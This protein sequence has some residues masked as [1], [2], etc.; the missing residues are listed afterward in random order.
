LIDRDDNEKG[1]GDGPI[2]TQHSNLCNSSTTAMMMTKIVTTNDT[3][4]TKRRKGR[5]SYVSLG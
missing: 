4:N 3:N 1:M 5:E 2:A